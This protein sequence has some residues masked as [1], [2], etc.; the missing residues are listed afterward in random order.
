[1]E[2]P[3]KLAV[4]FRKIVD[5]GCG[6]VRKAGEE[7]RCR[8]SAHADSAPSMYIRLADTKILVRCS[9]GCTFDDICNSLDHDPADLCFSDDEPRVEADEEFNAADP[10]SQQAPD[11]QPNPAAAGDDLGL[12][13][14][15]Y[16]ALL[17]KL[18]M[19]TDHFA[20]LIKRG[21]TAEQ[22]EKRGYRTA[23][24][25]TLSKATDNLLSQY[26]RDKLLTVLGLHTSPGLSASP[27][28][29]QAPNITA[30]S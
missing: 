13:H 20:S 11:A 14:E 8:C 18:E 6:P 26:Q 1:M 9:A 17:D 24:R 10:D 29:A 30:L 27:H 23:D 19:S 7:F 12:R 15:V 16:S 25:S 3:Y 22:I 21:L 28:I 2:V 4:F 5:A